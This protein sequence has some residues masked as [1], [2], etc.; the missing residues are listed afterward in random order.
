MKKVKPVSRHADYKKWLL[1]YLDFKSKYRLP[2]SKSEHVRLFVEKLQEKNQTPAQQKQAAHALSLYFE[3]LRQVDNKSSSAQI[4]TE[5]RLK[6]ISPSTA[7]VSKAGSSA[8]S[9]GVFILPLSSG[10]HYNA[11]RCLAKSGSPLRLCIGA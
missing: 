6:T 8:T 4:N 10:S 9:S 1:Y 7:N 2:D 5:K 3:I 11:W